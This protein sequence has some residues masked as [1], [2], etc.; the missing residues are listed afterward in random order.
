[1]YV[2]WV[3][4]VVVV[5]LLMGAAIT[6]TGASRATIQDSELTTVLDS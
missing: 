5:V 6:A 4:I 2:G 1:V 3:V